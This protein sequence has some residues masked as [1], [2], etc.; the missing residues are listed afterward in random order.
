MDDCA[1][2]LEHAR[3]LGRRPKRSWARPS[4][5]S[6]ERLDRALARAEA[7]R[8]RAGLTD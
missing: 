7:L 4:P 3:S 1:E 6:A 8:A 5:D 2:L